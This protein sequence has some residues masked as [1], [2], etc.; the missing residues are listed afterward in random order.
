MC[1]DIY[2]NVKFLKL[3]LANDMCFRSSLIKMILVFI[4]TFIK[5][6]DFFEVN[7]HHTKVNGHPSKG[8]NIST[9]EA[10]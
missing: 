9:F 6:V 10:F 7:I 3:E 2:M 8:N 5:A 4:S 1:L